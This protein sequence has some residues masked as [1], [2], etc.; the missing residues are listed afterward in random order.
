LFDKSK[1][2]TRGEGNSINLVLIIGI[3]VISGNRREASTQ[4]AV[5]ALG[6]PGCLSERRFRIEVWISDAAIS[7]PKTRI[8]GQLRQIGKAH[9]ITLEP[10]IRT[11]SRARGE[12]SKMLVQIDRA[13]TL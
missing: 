4:Q 2:E 5:I 13:R 8:D 12:D 6:I 9:T 7:R 10:L 1:V 3:A 11:S